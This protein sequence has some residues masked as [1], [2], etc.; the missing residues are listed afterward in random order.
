MV[1]P[2]VV[3]DSHDPPW[4][5]LGHKLQIADNPLKVALVFG[6]VAGDV[7]IEGEAYNILSLSSEIKTEFAY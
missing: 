2:H 4:V 1:I 6:L 3:V 7:T 5:V